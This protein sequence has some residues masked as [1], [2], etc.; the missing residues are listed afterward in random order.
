MRSP[1]AAW[2]GRERLARIP[3][4]QREK[5]VPL[6]PEFVVELTSPTDR[7]PEVKRKMEEWMANGCEL[8]WLLDVKR[9]RVH[10]YRTSG[11]QILDNPATVHGEGPVAG[12]ELDLAEI[13]HPAW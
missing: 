9:F 1:D 10:V 5:W 7:L 6:C 2:V 3:E 8:G 12:F 11:V 13:W 4:E